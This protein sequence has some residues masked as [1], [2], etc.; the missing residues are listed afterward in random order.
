[1]HISAAIWNPKIIYQEIE[2]LMKAILHTIL[3]KKDLE[4][5]EENCSKYVKRELTPHQISN[6]L[7]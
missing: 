2:N 3:T 1:L 6:D 7:A 4:K 5:V